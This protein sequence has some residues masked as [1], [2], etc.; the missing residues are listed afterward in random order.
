MVPRMVWQGLHL[1]D[2]GKFALLGTT[3]APAFE[4]DDFEIGDRNILI[5]QYPQYMKIIRKLT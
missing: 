4:Y 2:G 3:V 1:A 5:Q